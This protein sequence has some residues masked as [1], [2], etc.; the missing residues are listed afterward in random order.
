MDRVRW[1]ILST[2]NIGVTKV[3]PAMKKANRVDV[4]A[5]ASRD[6]KRAGEVAAQLGIGRTH[7]SYDAL[8][9]DPEIDAI[10]NPLPNHLHVEWSIKALEAGKHVLCEKPIGLSVGEAEQL[11]AA[12]ESYPHLRLMEA[13]MY[14]H[15]PQWIRARELVRSGEIGT[16]KAIQSLFSYYN[17]DPDNIRNQA[18][19]GGGGLM[20]IG[21]YP[22]SASRLL[23]GSEPRAVNAM[24]EFDSHFGTDTYG[25]VV[26]E[27]HG[28]TASFSYSTQL[29]PYQRVNI[30]GTDG[31]IEIQIPF[32]APPD[33]P[34]ILELQR[35]SETE[36]IEFP[37]ADQYALQAENMSLAIINDTPVPTPITDAVANM[38]VIERC[39]ASARDRRW[40]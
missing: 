25:S 34:C 4:A 32:N 23:Y 26:L 22:V 2:A 8:L 3:I 11:E 18:D 37:T 5:I 14:R 31:R 21:C 7:G 40:T 30:L 10:Y 38:R 20:D 35:G 28:G 13:F 9:A 17:V 29:A 16:L 33:R 12:G 19:V 6:G 27:F 36:R 15:H 39:F 1:G 24:I